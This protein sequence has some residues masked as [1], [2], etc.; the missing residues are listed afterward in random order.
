MTTRTRT[1]HGAWLHK[2]CL[3][4]RK[5]TKWSVR[6]AVT[7]SG[8]STLKAKRL[9][10]LSLESARS[11]VPSRSSLPRLHRHPPAVPPLCRTCLRTARQPT[12]HPRLRPTQTAT[13]LARARILSAPS[14]LCH[15]LTA[16]PGLARSPSQ[17]QH[18]PTFRHHSHRP[19]GRRTTRR[20]AITSGLRIFRPTTRCRRRL[21][22]RRLSR[23]PLATTAVRRAPSRSR[24]PR[25]C[26]ASRSRQLFSTATRPRQCR[27]AATT[28]SASLVGDCCS[29]PLSS[30]PVSCLA[31]TQVLFV[32]SQPI[33]RLSTF[34]LHYPHTPFDRNRSSP[35]STVH[36]VFLGSHNATSAPLA[37]AT[38]R[39]VLGPR[40]SVLAT[41]LA[42]RHSRIMITAAPFPD[43]NPRLILTRIVVQTPR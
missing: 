35:F 33:H 1:S 19:R 40:P 37:T 20:T 17:L 9:P 34:L 24:L 16:L 12:Q 42:G 6:C 10:T 29:P 2:R 30:L 21:R 41:A 38:F 28:P 22:V 31:R 25:P 13:A 4:S 8:P 43:L 23:A 39:S 18:R 26:R 15:L 7:S 14:V 27:S 5:S 3:R 11:S 32:C 36:S